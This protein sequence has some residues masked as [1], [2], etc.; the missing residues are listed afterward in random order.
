MARLKSQREESTEHMTKLQF[1]ITSV[2]VGMR[3]EDAIV[4]N[5]GQETIDRLV[6]FCRHKPPQ[7]EFSS[8]RQYLDYRRIDIATEQVKYLEE[9]TLCTNDW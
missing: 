6:E 7:Q 1:L 9:V 2:V 8:L 3:R 5:G 4:G